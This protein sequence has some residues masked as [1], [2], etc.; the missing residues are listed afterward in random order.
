MFVFPLV[1]SPYM[2]AHKMEKDERLSS[3]VQYEANDEQIMFKN[4]FSETK[5]DWGSFCRVIETKDLF[6]LVYTSNKNCS[7]MI[8]KRAF[9]SNDDEQ[10]FRDLVAAKIPAKQNNF[11]DIK[12]N[13]WILFTIIIPLVFCCLLSCGSMVVALI[14]QKFFN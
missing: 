5:L 14:N 3:P 11:F 6:L 1:I 9:A 10:A 13:R 7:Q 2:T 8:P 12:N 4:K